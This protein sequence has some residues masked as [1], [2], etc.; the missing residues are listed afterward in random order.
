MRATISLK[1]PYF[2]TDCSSALAQTVRPDVTGVIGR[3]SDEKV[4]VTQAQALQRVV[5]DLSGK[6]RPNSKHVGNL[7]TYL[8]E[9]VYVAVACSLD[10]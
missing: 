5:L 8:P 1:I 4:I 6:L 7:P 2:C 9:H 10:S 3:W